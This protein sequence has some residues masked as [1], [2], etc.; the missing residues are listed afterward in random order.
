MTDAPV[1][2]GILETV[3]CYDH[4]ERSA[5][6][7]FYDDVLGLARVAG[8]ESGTAYRLGPGV[9]LIFD[10]DVLSESDSPVSAHG[11]TGP[12]HACLLAAPDRYEEVRT[13]LE[14]EGVEITHDHEWP[15]GGRS[16]YFRDP[17]GN[18]LEVAD[19]DLWPGRGA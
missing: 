7:S 4:P 16:F 5:M 12:G 6:H 8:F 13:R 3:L 1:Y 14:A 18:L 2:A 15:G 9:L 10:R 11:T 17:A 19:R